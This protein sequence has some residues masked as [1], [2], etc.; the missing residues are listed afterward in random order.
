VL[1]AFPKPEGTLFPGFVP[2][3]LAAAGLLAHARRVR[4]LATAAPP[5]LQ[6]RRSLAGAAGVAAATTGLLAAAVL[7]AGRWI[8]L[9][10]KV[11]PYAANLSYVVPAALAACV[12]LVVLSP[13]ARIFVRGVPGSTRL[14]YIVALGTAV[15]LSFGRTIESMGYRVSNETLYG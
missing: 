9:L 8:P 1:Q 5:L 10:R 11:S 3:V 4:V 15:W 7:L 6:V 2:V 13:R 12:A 14:F